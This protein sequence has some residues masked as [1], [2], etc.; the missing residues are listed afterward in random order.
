MIFRA[1]C[2]V[3]CVKVNLRSVHR[4]KYACLYL[5]SDE[6]EDST[7]TM[8][9]APSQ[10]QQQQDGDSVRISA[11]I[12][13]GW[14]ALFSI[15]FVDGRYAVRTNDDRYLHRNGSLVPGPPPADATFA[16]EL[17]AGGA[18]LALRDRGGK[19]VTAVGRDAVVQGRNASA[20]KDE[21][22]VV[23]EG[24]PQVVIF[25]HNG[26]MV[27]IKQGLCIHHCF[28]GLRNKMQVPARSISVSYYILHY[29][30]ENDDDD[31][32]DIICCSSVV[33]NA[34]MDFSE[35]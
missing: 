9:Q 30:D 19:Y 17:K 12:P 5:A 35:L 1:A 4:Q 26:K 32:H 11:L 14:R 13:W 3:F 31:F 8:Q 18:G 15:Q 24:H 22:F 23:E 10:Q 20:G 2:A 25:A 27:S 34:S 21:L 33:V 7:S 28:P 6:D 16:V 29:S